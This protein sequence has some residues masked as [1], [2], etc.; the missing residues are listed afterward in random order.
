MVG[1]NESNLRCENEIGA[2]EYEEYDREVR[3]LTIE[4]LEE[5]IQQYRINEI[6][7]LIERTAFML[8]M[9]EVGSIFSVICHN[10]VQNHQEDRERML[11]IKKHD[12]QI[13]HI[14]LTCPS[15]NFY[16]NF[17]LAYA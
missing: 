15:H 3:L 12:E 7:D 5:A 2:K 11:Q 10:E 6:H 8:G 17:K 16:G 13:D 9:T 14:E 4:L 1:Q